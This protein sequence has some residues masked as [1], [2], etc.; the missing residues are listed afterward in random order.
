M[1]RPYNGRSPRARARKRTR[2]RTETRDKRLPLPL[3][4]PRL[5][6]DSRRNPRAT[7]PSPSLLPEPH[8]TA[9]IALAETMLARLTVA[10]RTA[11]VELRR[12]EGH[13]IPPVE[14]SSVRDKDSSV[15]R[16]INPIPLPLLRL[17]F[18]SRVTV[19]PVPS[20]TAE[21]IAPHAQPKERLR[22][23]P[24]RL[25]GSKASAVLV[26]SVLPSRG[27]IAPPSRRVRRPPLRSSLIV[28]LR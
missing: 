26:L 14:D 11:P 24:L 19:V 28:P 15:P 6:S 17:G 25:S 8:R 16:A 18:G 2:T 5:L 22:R 3:Q 12:A 20:V 1:T 9:R 10:H 7:S 21:G 13:K 23:L 27:S 4:L